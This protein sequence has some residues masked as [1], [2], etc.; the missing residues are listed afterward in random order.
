[1]EYGSGELLRL[2][3]VAFA[4]GLGAGY[5][6]WGKRVAETLLPGSDKAATE[7]ETAP[8]TT[9]APPPEA[10]AEDQ[11]RGSDPAAEAPQSRPPAPTEARAPASGPPPV[12][13]APEP[14]PAAQAS[15]DTSPEGAPEAAPAPGPEKP[16]VVLYDA[17][18]ETV[19]DLQK[20]KGIGPKMEAVL[21]TNGIYR[22]D[23]LAAFTE[24]DL[25]WL[26]AAT[27]SF[28]GRAAR[29]GWAAQAAALLA[30]R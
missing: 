13:A 12:A 4:L 15:T 29:D 16:S 5:L 20:I 3:L 21:N 2:V 18:P 26:D 17:P 7:A 14:E 25:G 8:E 28:P 10:R 27:G 1:M 11:P 30:E 9:S 19:D 22:Y 23:Q 24:A 6:I